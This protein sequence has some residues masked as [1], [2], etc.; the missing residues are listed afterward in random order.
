MRSSAEVNGKKVKK[1]YKINPKRFGKVVAVSL[2]SVALFLSLGYC[3]TKSKLQGIEIDP[4]TGYTYG[5]NGYNPS[6]EEIVKEMFNFGK[7]K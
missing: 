4:T 3:A 7:G 5:G 6:F 1:R 2:L